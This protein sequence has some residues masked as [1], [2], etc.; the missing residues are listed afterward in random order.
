MPKK[1]SVLLEKLKSELTG[2]LADNLVGIYL[3]GSYVL[4]SYNEQVSDLDYIVVVIQPLSPTEKLALM[5]KTLTDLWPLAP[6][7]GLE[8][9]VLLLADC[10]QFS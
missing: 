10:Q 2:I 9:H 3:H 6:A 4:G 7:K 8:F 5:T 1:T